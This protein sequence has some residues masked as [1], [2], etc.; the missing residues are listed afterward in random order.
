MGSKIPL[1]ANVILVVPF[2][3]HCPALPL[4]GC[5][6]CLQ[7]R[8]A[9]VSCEGVGQLRGDLQARKRSSSA[10]E[11]PDNGQRGDRSLLAASER[12]DG[13]DDDAPNLDVSVVLADSLRYLR[14]TVARTAGQR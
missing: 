11:T 6:V 7:R 4:A 2:R 8:T 13:R 1:R 5:G 10:S 12:Q 14:P 9:W 3:M